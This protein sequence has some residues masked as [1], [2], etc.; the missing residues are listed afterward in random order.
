MGAQG[1]KSPRE[2]TGKGHATSI[3]SQTVSDAFRACLARKDHRGAAMLLMA[4]TTGLRAFQLA[5]LTWGQVLDGKGGVGDEVRVPLQKTK[6]K[7]ESRTLPLP[8]KTIVALKVLFDETKLKGPN[9]PIFV[10]QRTRKAL[11]AQS[12]VDW[13]RRIFRRIGVDAS[14]HSARRYFITQAARAMSQARGSTKDLMY[15]AQ[16]RNYQTTARYIDT[17]PEAQGKMAA[18]VAQQI[19]I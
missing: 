18:L 11:T 1:K 7:H 14:A 16:H 9:D 3:T 10:S 4:T 15:L 6:G 13:F 17:D 8:N 19:R 12:V 2:G 5:A